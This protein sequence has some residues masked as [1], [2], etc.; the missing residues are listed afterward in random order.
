M[1]KDEGGRMKQEMKE[2]RGMGK[3]GTGSFTDFWGRNRIGRN[4]IP[5]AISIATPRK[6]GKG[7]TCLSPSE[8]VKEEI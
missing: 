1:M 5:I 2:K 3:L 4:P 8:T 6:E 7:R